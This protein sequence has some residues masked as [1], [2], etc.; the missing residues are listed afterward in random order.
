MDSLGVK[1]TSCALR[2][3]DRE[4]SHCL[5]F[6]FQSTN[7]SWYSDL[8]KGWNSNRSKDFP[9]LQIIQTGS[10]AHTDSLL[11]IVYRLSSLDL[12]RSERDAD[13]FAPP[14]VHFKLVELHFYSQHTPSFLGL[15]ATACFYLTCL[16]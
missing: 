4:S 15:L 8:A 14:S 7:C 5:A 2:G 6:Q 13:H 3:R 1:S 9:L 11:F 12:K 16:F 10:G